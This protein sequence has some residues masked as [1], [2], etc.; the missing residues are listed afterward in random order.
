MS[1]A[2]ATAIF[3][4]ALS[5]SPLLAAEEQACLTREQQR[6]AV[7]DGQAIPLAA[8][9]KTVRGHGRVVGAQLCR[10]PKGLVYVLT[11]LAR[12]GKVTHARVEAAHGGL[13]NGD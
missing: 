3:L 1:R 12:D 10:E 2:L 7:A 6:A 5:A 8:A 9:F 13:I 11:V 4:L